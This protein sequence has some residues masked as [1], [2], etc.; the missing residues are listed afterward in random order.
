MILYCFW[1]LWTSPNNQY[2]ATLPTADHQHPTKSGSA[3]GH[4]VIS[5]NTFK[6]LNQNK[7]D[8]PKLVIAQSLCFLCRLIKGYFKIKDIWL[9][10][11]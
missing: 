4:V 6:F 3:D 2:A 7:N 11:Y 10:L 9:K 8:K 5:P 1:A